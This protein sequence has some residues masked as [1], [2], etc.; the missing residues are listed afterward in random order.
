M[1]GCSTSAVCPKCKHEFECCGGARRWLSGGG[2]I[3]AAPD[4]PLFPTPAASEAVASP[5]T[6]LAFL[7]PPFANGPTPQPTPLQVVPPPQDTDTELQRLSDTV[8][9]LRQSGWYYEGL[10]HRES[11]DLLK[12]TE[13][14]TF[15]VRDSSD[16]RYLFSLSVQTTRGPT[17]VR[18]HYVRGYFRLDAQAHLQPAMPLFPSV[19]HLV[20]HYVGQSKFCTNSPQVWVDS[21]GKWYSPILLRRPLRRRESPASLKHLARMAVQRGLRE[22]GGKSPPAALELPAS[23]SAYLDEYPFTL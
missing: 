12:G 4:P 21:M 2:I 8:R 15:L 5:S 19:M 6:P 16:P 10:G 14:G 9:A 17:S 18:L 23:L 7:L 22:G 20:E 1:L 3:A 13:P 11:D